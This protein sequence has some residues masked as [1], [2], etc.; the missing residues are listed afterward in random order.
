MAAMASSHKDK[1]LER[2]AQA[3]IENKET[4]LQANAED[5]RK[6][7][8][9]GLSEPLIKRLLLSESKL[10]DAVKGIRD[11]AL[12]PDP[13]GK[14]TYQN[15]MDKNLELYRVTCP[16]GVIGIIF[17]ARPDALIQISALCL[18]SSNAV[19]LKGGTE[20]NGTNRALTAVIKKASEEEGIPDGWISL[21]LTRTDVMELLKMDGKV[22]LI[23][24]RG[25]NQF[26]QMI[27]N[28]TRIP[29]LGHADGVCHTYVDEDCDMEMAIRVLL[30]AKTQYVAVCNATET[31]LVHEKIADL[32]LPLLKETFDKNHVEIFG[33]PRR[34]PEFWD[35]GLLPTGIQNTL[36]M[37]C[38]S[39]SSPASTRRSSHINR[40]GSRHTDAIITSNEQA[41]RRFM[42]LVDAGNV[43][44][45]CSTRFSDGFRYG[46][47]AE[48]GV[49]TSKIHARG[50]VGLEGPGNLQVQIIRQWT[51]CGGLFIGRILLSPFADR[52]G[53]SV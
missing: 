10:L 8:E 40:Y 12:L 45:N 5:V 26:V 24:P 18:K 38:P 41:A 14:T 9:D 16:I 15:Q 35:A 6:A 47:G 22:D 23:I 31:I 39:G 53:M 27:M 46:F 17:E 1:A 4:I 52:Q 2:I 19:L 48:V 37:R 43:F 34:H 42:S 50:P 49:S 25:S 7:K 30:D 3:L 32:L 21:L 20:A 29:V 28:N 11:M 13:I 44:W 33:L 51:D 36:T